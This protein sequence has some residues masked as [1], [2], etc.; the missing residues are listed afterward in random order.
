M[1]ENESTD[2][3]ARPKTEDQSA[4]EVFACNQALIDS[5]REKHGD[6]EVI[7]PRGL[8][9][10]IVVKTPP[11]AAYRAFL[12]EVQNE[13][14]SNANAADNISY[15]SVVHP[16]RETL[17]GFFEQ[18]PGLPFKIAALAQSLSGADSDVLGKG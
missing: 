14:V 15:A 16:D 3:E 1:S 10:I 18:K 9:G 6:I 12:A 11:R 2:A 7:R 17:K 5:L 4:D 13:K 8:P